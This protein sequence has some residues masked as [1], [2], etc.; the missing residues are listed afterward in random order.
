MKK[1]AESFLDKDNNVLQA[2]E[3]LKKYL[4]TTGSK[5]REYAPIAQHWE[6]KGYTLP[7]VEGF[8][9]KENLDKIDQQLLYEKMQKFLAAI[10]NSIYNQP[11]E[12]FDERERVKWSN[13]FSKIQ[14]P[15]ELMYIYQVFKN[16]ADPSKTSERRRE[17]D[18][19]KKLTEGREYFNKLRDKV[20]EIKRPENPNPIN[21]C[22]EIYNSLDPDL[23]VKYYKKYLTLKSKKGTGLDIIKLTND[24]ELEQKERGSK[25]AKMLLKIVE[26]KQSIKNIKI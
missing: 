4:V 25:V 14:D 5:K 12:E 8:K 11:K 2:E 26:A 21:R 22:L 1:I 6:E 24:I 23:A 3:E 13:V 18:V 20:E 15:T 17:L 9:I 10:L 19:N 16:R 7:P